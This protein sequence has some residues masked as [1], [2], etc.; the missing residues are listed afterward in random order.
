MLV[1]LNKYKVLKIF[2]FFSVTIYLFFIGSEYFN[3]LN[4]AITLNVQ[5][6]QN[7]GKQNGYFLFFIEE[8]RYADFAKIIFSFSHIFSLENL[9]FLN[10]PESWISDLSYIEVFNS[11]GANGTMSLPPITIIILTISAYIVK[12]IGIN[13]T[14]VYKT[15]I[16]LIV[17][18]LLI[19]LIEKLKESPNLIFI[20][21]SFP[22]LFLIDRGNIWAAVSG[23]FLFFLFK[24]FIS[25]NTL[26]N[27][28]LAYFILAS[29]FRPNY[30]VFGLLFLYRKDVKDS[31]IEFFK[32]GILYTFVNS[33]FFSIAVRIFP[34]YSFENFMFMVSKYSEGEIRFD[35]WNSSLHGLIYNLYSRFIVGADLIY[36]ESD[37]NF[38]K[39]FILGPNLNLVIFIFYLSV[40][41][42]AYIKLKNQEID[43]ISFL[44]VLCSFTAITTSPFADYHLII[45]IFLFFLIYDLQYESKVQSINLIL[46][47]LILLP[48]VHLLTPDLN[49]HNLVNVLC[50]NLLIII[51]FKAKRFKNERISLL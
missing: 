1:K 6:S 16:L 47:S 40:L 2:S 24:S 36:S 27:L 5:T 50:L 19:K 23:I 37:D 51:N 48:K 42:L 28:D 8:D 21:F 3:L 12:F 29:S 25:K 13:Y 9:K 41:F 10:V 38:I 43:V 26:S 30:L 49:F 18:F 39:Q 44:I 34:D 11:T 14:I 22:F 35:T 32:I 33:I 45:F 20:L 15:V 46:L 17:L 7:L 31:F 4:G